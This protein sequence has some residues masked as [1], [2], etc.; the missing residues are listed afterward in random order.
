MKDNIL[1]ICFGIGGASGFVFERM[2]KKLA[3]FYNVK[4]IVSAKNY[5]TEFP[6]NVIVREV[7]YVRFPKQIVPYL[8]KRLILSDTGFLHINDIFPKK[9]LS[10]FGRNPFNNR[11]VNRI[12]NSGV[13]LDRQYS[14]VLGLM[15]SHRYMT[16]IATYKIAKAL[17]VKSIVYSTDA[18]PTT[19]AWEKDSTFLRKS[20]KLLSQYFPKLNALYFS[21]E[22]MLKYE[23]SL[24]EF[25]DTKIRLGVLLTN[26]PTEKIHFTQPTSKMFLYTGAAWGPRTPY[27]VFNAFKKLLTIHPDAQ[28]C[29]VG[30]RSNGFSDEE[31]SMFS[32]DERKS[33]LSFP[34]TNNLIPFYEKACCYIDLNANTL[35][36]PYLSSKITN[37]ILYNRPIICETSSD[38]AAKLMFSNLDSIYICDH[39]ENDIFQA[40]CKVLSHEPYDYS[41]RDKII[42][43][44]SL[45]TIIKKFNDEIR[46]VLK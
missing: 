15:D 22:V 25:D 30:T 20:V 37:Y 4:L 14:F 45:E 13:L 11:W 44:F 40:M 28:L 46:I 27:F 36:D 12:I 18:N 29:F 17:K 39:K 23:K 24:Y 42:N 43:E 16:P 10:L 1:I 33:I 38:S 41:E 5:K 9:L 8:K 21:N 31:L 35:N 26:S 6:S 2:I 7:P 34:R 19:P 32:E 3:D